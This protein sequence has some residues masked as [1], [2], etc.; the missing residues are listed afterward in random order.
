MR[1]SAGSFERDTLRLHSEDAARFYLRLHVNF[2]TLAHDQ[3]TVHVGMESTVIRVRTL[4]FD[5]IA[6]RCSRCYAPRVKALASVGCGVGNRVLVFPHNCISNIDSQTLRSVLHPP[7]G[8]YMRAWFSDCALQ[9]HRS[10]D[11]QCHAIDQ[12]KA[13]E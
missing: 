4:L 6:P 13:R 5:H 10:R 7:N 9:T 2:L 11:E 3:L 8:D 12:Q 1:F